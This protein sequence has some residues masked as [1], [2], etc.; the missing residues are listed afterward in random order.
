MA[1]RLVVEPRHGSLNYD[2]EAVSDETGLHCMDESL[3]V[4]SEAEDADINVIVKRFGLTGQLPRDVRM[5]TYGDFNGVSDYREALDA[6]R[7]ADASF[8]ALPA[9]VRSRFGN[10]AAA[11]VD[12]CS[13]A[14]NL[15]ELRAMGLAVAKE[16]DDGKAGR[17]AESVSRSGRAGGS[18]D[19]ES[20]SAGEPQ[21]GE[22]RSAGSNAAGS[23]ARRSRDA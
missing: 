21:G 17:A 5:P 20:E 10:D 2:V 19:S 18:G 14:D 6:V 15:D 11:F 23:R 9:S 13:N 7:A 3:T 4:Q 22:G 1:K 8:M 12:F 16:S